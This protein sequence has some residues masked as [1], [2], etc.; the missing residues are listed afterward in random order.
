MKYM[1]GLAWVSCGS[2]MCVD[3]ENSE[4][5]CH[6]LCVLCSRSF[7]MAFSCYM[8]E[9]LEGGVHQ[10]LRV[11][12]FNFCFCSLPHCGMFVC[13]SLNSC[14]LRYNLY[15]E[16]TSDMTQRESHISPKRHFDNIED[17]TVTEATEF[18]KT[19]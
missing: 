9:F 17:F 8:M 11:Q 19:Y 7:K 1:H 2:H 14:E 5:P 3:R 13:C 10:H 6:Q 12:L 16:K 4:P 18:F 15:F